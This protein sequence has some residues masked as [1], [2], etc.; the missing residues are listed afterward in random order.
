MGLSAFIDA[1]F[2]QA[3]AP[4]Q[5]DGEH[6]A[7]NA[8]NGNDH[9]GQHE[10]RDQA[11]QDRIPRLERCPGPRS[12]NHQQSR[13]EP[14]AEEIT[15]Y[16]EDEAGDE[17]AV[18]DQGTVAGKAQD[19]QARDREAAEYE[20]RMGDEAAAERALRAIHPEHH[21]TQRRQAQPQGQ[22]AGLH[23]RRERL[24]G[25]SRRDRRRVGWIGQLRTCSLGRFFWPAGSG[26]PSAIF[27]LIAAAEPQLDHRLARPAE[28]WHQLRHRLHSRTAGRIACGRWRIFAWV[29]T[30][31]AVVARLD[32]AIQ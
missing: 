24:C 7:D 28:P 8:G 2:D 9:R 3:D 10:D 12:V 18:G 14:T 11:F 23:R 6:D 26:A 19:Q 21:A 31:F 25:R 16:S 5:A 22:R 15:G 17:G 13:T 29:D 27:P 20:Q 1:R 4:V 30:H 32:R